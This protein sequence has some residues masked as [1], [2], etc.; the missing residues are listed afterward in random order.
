MES[1]L[2]LFTFLSCSHVP[3]PANPTGIAGEPRAHSL[4]YSEGNFRGSLRRP[5]HIARA[6]LLFYSIATRVLDMRLYFEKSPPHMP[7][8]DGLRIVGK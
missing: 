5:P 6:P 3:A 7:I 2:R 4:Q 1:A 8:A